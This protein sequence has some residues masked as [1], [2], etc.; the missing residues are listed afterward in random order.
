MARFAFIQNLWTENL[1]I[2][3]LSSS[4]Q[5]AGY[6]ARI[7]IDV[8]GTEALC[9]VVEYN[10]QVVGVSCTTGLH[11]WGVD[12]LRRA[13]AAL[14]SVITL[15]GGPHATFCPET[16]KEEGVDFAVMGEAE[17]AIVSFAEEFLGNREFTLLENLAFAREGELV[18]NPLGH[19]VEEL[20]SLPFPD[21]SHYDRY[22]VTRREGSRNFIGG[23]GCPYKCA[24]CGNYQYHSLYQGKG[25]W[26]RYRSQENVLAEIEEV[27]DRYGIKFVGFSDDTLI[28]NRKWLLPFLEKYRARIGLPFISTVRANLVDEEMV[29]ALKEAGCQSCVFGVESG[30]ERIRNETLLKGVT[31]EEIRRT[32]S[33]FKKHKIRFGT[34]NMLGLPG[35]TVEDAMQTV[36]LNSQIRPDFPWCSV[37]Q[38]Y[39]GTKIH[40]D[41]EKS[42]GAEISADEIGASYFTAS[43]IDNPHI[44]QMENLQ[45]FFHLAVRY[46]FLQPLIRLLIKLPPNPL[47][48]LVFQASYGW[49]L[50]RRSSLNP[51]QMLKY[52][53]TQRGIFQSKGK[54]KG[55][56]RVL[57][58]DSK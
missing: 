29:G 58:A 39:P 24:F 18:I 11:H 45:K 43:V 13:K 22:L 3:Y 30:V 55:G 32:A 57:A 49:Q 8:K 15:I 31:D 16:A 44:K 6:E 9:E 26:V 56:E 27:R 46:R 2:M 51:L 23:R 52:W 14:P 48:T 47:F 10:P 38:P 35:E 12:F 34:Y 20:D 25:R 54:I 19:L 36:K 37:L 21:R 50:L 4:L 7:F 28:F 41:M 53:W 5:A 33:L 40:A 1:G 42:L 17:R